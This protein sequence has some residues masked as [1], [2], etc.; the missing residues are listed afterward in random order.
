[1]FPYLE[2]LKNSTKRLL[3]LIN[4][5]SKVVGYKINLKKSV[6]FPFAKNEFMKKEIQKTVPFTIT[7]KPIKYLGI[8]LT[9][10]VNDIYKENYKTLKKLKRDLGRWK[11]LPC[12]WIGRINIIKMAILPKV[13]YRINAIPIKMP[14]TFF[15]DLE[16]QSQIL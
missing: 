9:K 4:Q 10:D 3:E 6:A 5:Y 15:R 12:L 11:D 1:M 13:I 14:M 2:D 7:S 16:N 8:N